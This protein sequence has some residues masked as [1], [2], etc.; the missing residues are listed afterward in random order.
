MKGPR[1]T[2]EREIAFWQ[3]GGGLVAGLDEAGRGPLAGPV[4]AAAVVFPPHCRPIR[5]LRDSKLL[6]AVKRERL[7][8]LVWTR[9]LAVGVGAASVREIDRWNIRRASILA[10]RRALAHLAVQPAHILVDGLPAPELGCAHEAIV[11][12]D[13][14]CHSIAA[15][16]V[17]AKTLRDRLM[18][19]LARK[20][21]AYA[22]TTNKGY[23]TPDHLAALAT[24]GF[25]VHHRKSFAPV[26]QL[27][28]ATWGASARP[29]PAAP[30]A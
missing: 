29:G 8:H 1:P 25:T 24:F 10:M 28:L 11:D 4:V 15:A 18:G 23:A 16:S 21:P 30:L 14:Y 13:A 7:A 9:A 12:G 27:E 6:P 22:W 19:L 2:L 20:Y 5:G 3:A 17:V 26:V